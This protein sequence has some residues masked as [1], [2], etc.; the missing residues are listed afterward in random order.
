MFDAESHPRSYYPISWNYIILQV[1]R[2]RIG[3]GVPY[4]EEAGSGGAMIPRC[5]GNFENENQFSF[6]FCE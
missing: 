1:Y 6:N 5:S 2:D 3:N 4:I